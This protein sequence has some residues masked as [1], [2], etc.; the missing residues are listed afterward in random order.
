MYYRFFAASYQPF[1]SRFTKLCFVVC[2]LSAVLVAPCKT[3]PYVDT[4]LDKRAS[5]DSFISTE[6]PIALA[7]VLANIGANGVD[8]SGADSGVVVASPSKSNP[9]YFYT[10]T[11]DSALTIK[12]LVDRLIAGNAALQSTIDNY[13]RAQA[14]IQQMS[15]PSGGPTTGGLGEPKFNVDE[16]AFTGSWGRPQRDGPALRATALVAYSRYLIAKGNTSYVTNTVWPIISKDLNYVVTYWNQTGF[17]LWEEVDGSSFFTYNAQHRALVEGNSLASELGQT[18]N[19]CS[20]QAPLVLCFLQSFWSGTYIFSNI[21]V[22]NGRSGKDANSILSSIQVFDPAATSCD[23]ATFQPCS[24]RMLANHKAVTD[25]FR[26]IY[27]INSG[28]AEGSAV[29]VGRYAEDVYYNGNPWYLN[30]LAAAEQLYDAL[31]QW[32]KIGSLNVTSTSLAFFKDLDSSITTGIYASSSATYSTLTSVVKTYADGYVSK[33]QQYTPSTGFLTEQYERSTGTPLSAANL[34]WS[35]AAFL[36]AADRRAGSV[37]ASWG[38]SSANTIPSNCASGGSGCS[39]K[40]TFNESKTTTFG[41][42]VYLTG[43]ISA[44]SSWSTTSA[45]ALSA[46]G[47]TAANPVWSVTVNLPA[48]TG[49]EYKFFVKNTDGSI[50]WEGDPNRSYT[51]SSTC[52]SSATVNGS[53]R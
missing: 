33:V 51:T 2:L 47:Y 13:V 29:A 45:I 32:N 18:C 23:D 52:G 34:T 15:N 12:A 38:S 48:G 31:Y 39:V 41:Q 21:N 37:P 25:S 17:D 3:A 22:N 20:T 26:S 5:V 16:T 40:I 7:G 10:W 50:T 49:F 6:N 46:S 8:A 19:G 44:L 27:G 24:D 36:T 11:R 30:T 9:D 4:P 35:Y 43:S 14:A 53:W 42:T 28:I 1:V